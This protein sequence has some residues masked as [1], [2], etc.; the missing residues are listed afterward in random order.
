MDTAFHRLLHSM[1][2]SVFKTLLRA[3]RHFQK[4]AILRIKTLQD[5]LGNQQFQAT[6]HLL[7]SFRIE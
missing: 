2:V 5:G 1:P 4:P 3:G 6:R 7:P